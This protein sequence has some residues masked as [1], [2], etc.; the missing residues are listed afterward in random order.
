[1]PQPPRDEK[2]RPYI[3]EGLRTF[4]EALRSANKED[5]PLL[6]PARILFIHG[7]ARR[8]AR[9]S[10]RPLTMGGPPPSFRH[11][12]WEKPQIWINGQIALY[13]IVLRP[14][15]FL[16]ATA[17]ERASIVAHE[18]WHMSPTF[19]GTLAPQR[20]HRDPRSAIADTVTDRWIAQWKTEG[21]EGS[22][23]FAFR[24]EIRLPAWTERP[25]SRLASTG[26]RRYTQ[27]DLH[28]AIVRQD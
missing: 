17:D 9:A 8:A 16:Q 27:E 7:A 12:D 28:S 6:D 18:L 19:D 13:E 26:R 10:V 24:G 23:V 21:A 15:Y 25:P 2:S 1:M 22:W 3:E 5:L 4:C 11:N 14:R 20:R